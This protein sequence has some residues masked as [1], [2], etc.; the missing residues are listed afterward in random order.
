MTLVE[1]LEVKLQMRKVCNTGHYQNMHAV[2]LFFC[3][4]A[5]LGVMPF[6]FFHMPKK[7]L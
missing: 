3:S 4:F 2:L 1:I 7:L 6:F 5:E